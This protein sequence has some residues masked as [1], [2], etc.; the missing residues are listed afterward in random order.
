M[1][2]RLAGLRPITRLQN[3]N[4]SAPAPGRIVSGCWIA[5]LRT[6][7]STARGAKSSGR[8]RG[9]RGGALAS[10]G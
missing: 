5:S 1:P 4:P 8:G 9:A 10:A 2:A 6:A 7:R 3:A